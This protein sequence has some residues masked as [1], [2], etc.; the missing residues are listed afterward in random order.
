MYVSAEFKGELNIVRTRAEGNLNNETEAFIVKNALKVAAE[1][2]CHKLLFDY[3][4]VNDTASMLEIYESPLL[5]DLWGVT[6]NFSIAVLY[7]E[8]EKNFKFWETRMIN[9]GFSARVFR[10]EDQALQWLSSDI[11]Y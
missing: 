9:E 5:F 8:D 7:S 10:N 4:K 1:E 2:K 11:P 6:R 3:S